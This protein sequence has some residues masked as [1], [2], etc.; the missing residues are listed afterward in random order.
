[1]I[2]QNAN[3]DEVSVCVKQ[4]ESPWFAQIVHKVSFGGQYV[5]LLNTPMSPLSSL[6]SRV[7]YDADIRRFLI[8]PPCGVAVGKSTR[9]KPKSMA[10]T[11]WKGD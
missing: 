1:M 2:T 9:N 10:F 11:Y 5:K 3:A 8:A 6:V 7:F 4:W